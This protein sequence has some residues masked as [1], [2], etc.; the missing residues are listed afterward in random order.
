MVDTTKAAIAQLAGKLG[1]D[2]T[3]VTV[4]SSEPVT[5]RDGSIGCPKKGMGYTQ[6]LVSGYL[7]ILA[8]DGTTY[9]YHAGSSGAPFLCEGEAQDPLPPGD[10]PA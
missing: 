2:A 5:W 8:V 10:G 9:R 4:V 6:M 1:V 7:V 3:S